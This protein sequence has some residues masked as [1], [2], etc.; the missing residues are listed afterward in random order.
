ML[1]HIMVEHGD[2]MA[3][4][5]NIVWSCRL[6]DTQEENEDT[7]LEHIKQRHGYLESKIG[8]KQSRAID[9]PEENQPFIKRFKVEVE[10]RLRKLAEARSVSDK[11]SD[12]TLSDDDED[13]N[14]DNLESEDKEIDEGEVEVTVTRGQR[15]AVM[16]YNLEC[17]LKETR[18]LKRVLVME[19]NNN[20]I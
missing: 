2:K 13:S 3:E 17:L 19:E 15:L 12:T 16:K 8:G 11:L 20:D 6:C 7:I 10:K 4:T 5:G 18:D 1:D 9:R 14:E